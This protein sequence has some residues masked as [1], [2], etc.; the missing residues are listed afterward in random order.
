MSA[1]RG[2]SEGAKVVVPDVLRHKPRRDHD[3]RGTEHEEDEGLT[4]RRN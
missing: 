4:E 2:D 3:E 1:V